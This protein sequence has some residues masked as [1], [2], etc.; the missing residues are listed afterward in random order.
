MTATAA[1]VMMQRVAFEGFDVASLRASLSGFALTLPKALRL[2][3]R[4]TIAAP[5]TVAGVFHHRDDDNVI[6]RT[7]KLAVVSESTKI[8]APEGA[9]LDTPEFEGEPARI[10]VANVSAVQLV[11]RSVLKIG[12]RRDVGAE[13]SVVAVN[14]HRDPD[15]NLIVRTHKLKV[16]E[17]DFS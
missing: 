4:L 16:L 6:V 11:P 9:E 12:D 13:A 14:H 7:H 17:A 2:E 15:S 8:M 1:P 5:V 3:A 10:F